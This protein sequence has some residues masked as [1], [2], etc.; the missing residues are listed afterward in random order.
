MLAS[1][2]SSRRLQDMSSRRLQDMCSRLHQDMSS[3]CL[4]DMS[5]RRLEDVFSVTIFRLLRRLQDVLEDVKLLHW[6]RVEVVFK[7]CLEDVFKTNKC[8]LGGVLTTQRKECTC[9]EQRTWNSTHIFNS[10]IFNF[11]HWTFN[12]NFF[13]ENFYSVLEMACNKNCIA[14]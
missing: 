6:R 4:Q 3:R 10:M 9:V 5:S 13:E 8:L 7:T 14:I 1:K 11:P 2:T 12:N